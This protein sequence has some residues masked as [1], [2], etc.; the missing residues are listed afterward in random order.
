MGGYGLGGA[1]MTASRFADSRGVFAGIVEIAVVGYVLIKAWRLLRR[2]LLIW[3]QEATSRRRRDDR[4]D[5]LTADGRQTLPCLC[6]LPDAEFLAR[7]GPRHA[8]LL[9]LLTLPPDVTEQYRQRY[10]RTFPEL[11]IDVVATRDKA[12]AALAEADMLLTFGQMMKNLKLDLDDA[13]QP[14]M[15][16]GARHRPRRHHRPAGAQARASP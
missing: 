2:R 5:G 16:A 12:A 13:A 3:H 8:P 4:R 7:Q 10:S 9:I 14:E 11:A 6:V 1:M 15:G